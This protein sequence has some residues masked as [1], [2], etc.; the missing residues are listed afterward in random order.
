[1]LSIGSRASGLAVRAVAQCAG[2]RVLTAV[3]ANPVLSD[4]EEK[5]HTYPEV[6][7]YEFQDI[8]IHIRSVPKPK[9]TSSVSLSQDLMTRGL[10]VRSGVAGMV[11]MI[12]HNLQPFSRP[13]SGT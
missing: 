6:L 4:W 10:S 8:P 7:P 5:E 3:P 13:R 12:N 1:M 2:G 11:L 9:P